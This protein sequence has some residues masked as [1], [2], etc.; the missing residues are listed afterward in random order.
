MGSL[1][2]IDEDAG[3]TFTYTMATAPANVFY[4]R[5]NDVLVGAAF[6]DLNP[7]DVVTMNVTTTDAGGLTLTRSVST[8]V[9]RLESSILS[10][11]G[12]VT[13]VLAVAALVT[14]A[15]Y[16]KSKSAMATTE[17]ASGAV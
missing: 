2:T 9:I 16:V 11:L 14:A 15:F 7:G 12:I 10:V 5:S 8:D 3:D 13:S 6:D 17:E 4:L 1:S